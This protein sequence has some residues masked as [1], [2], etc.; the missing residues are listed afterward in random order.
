MKAIL[1]TDYEELK[2]IAQITQDLSAKYT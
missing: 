1:E 2:K